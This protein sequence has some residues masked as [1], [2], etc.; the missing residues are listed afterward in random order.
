M[1]KKSSPKRNWETGQIRKSTE[2]VNMI[3]AGNLN[4]PQFFPDLT[5]YVM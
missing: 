5:C 4:E 2:I 1:G 3:A